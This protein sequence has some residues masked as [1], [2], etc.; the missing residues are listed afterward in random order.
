MGIL[1]FFGFSVSGVGAFD[2]GGYTSILRWRGQRRALGGV[3]VGVL[4]FVDAVSVLDCK[5]T[6]RIEANRALITRAVDCRSCSPVVR[7]TFGAPMRGVVIICTNLGV[8]GYV[9]FMGVAC[10]CGTIIR[11][12]SGVGGP[13]GLVGERVPG[14]T[15]ICVRGRTGAPL[16]ALF[17]GGRS[18]YM[19]LIGR[20]PTFLLRADRSLRVNAL[21]VVHGF[22]E[23][24]LRSV[25]GTGI[26]SSYTVTGVSSSVTIVGALV[27][28]WC[29][30]S[31]VCLIV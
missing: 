9:L 14:F 11:R 28:R 18:S 12:C 26:L 22:T 5:G 16:S 10:T 2:G 7:L 27:P 17:F 1:P 24:V 25:C 30:L 21:N 29:K 23:I 8:R 6:V 3:A 4:P 20:K 13:L 31:A 15:R 19:L